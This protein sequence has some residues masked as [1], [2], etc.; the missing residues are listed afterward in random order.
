MKPVTQH[1]AATTAVLIG[2]AAA[3]FGAFIW[4]GLYD[5]SADDPH[6]APVT[7]LLGSLRDR[8]IAARADKLRVPGLRD[9]GRIVQ[10]AGNYDAMCAGCHLAPGLAETELSKGLYPQ[11]P[12]LSKE[13]VAAA[14]AFWVIKHGIKASGM[15][16]WGKSMS[17]EYVWNLAAFLQELPTLD[18]K[19]YRERVAQSSGHSHGGGE[20]H[21][22]AHAEGSMGPAGMAAGSHRHGDDKTEAPAH[23]A[24]S[25]THGSL[26]T[27]ADGKKHVH[28]VKQATGAPSARSASA[29]AE[30]K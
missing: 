29:G 25:H 4:S 2:G 12:N 13:K 8:S 1:V 23:D 19:R 7:F 26:H 30:S 6:T 9:E 10:G 17:D 3:A 11:P 16:A 15:P 27:H 14:A 28:A 22:D 24:A 18:E 20:T 21:T 5:F